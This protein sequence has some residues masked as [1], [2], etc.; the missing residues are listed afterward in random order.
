[1]TPS[2]RVRAARILGM[3]ADFVQ[4][5]LLPFFSPGWL[6]PLND[7]LDVVVA[8]A[9]IALVGWHWAFLPAFLAELIPVFDLVPSWTAAVLI[10][11]RNAPEAVVPAPIPGEGPGDRPPKDGPARPPRLP[12]A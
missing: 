11:T 8:I 5:G 2:G 6:S 1:V 9:M 3:T 12:P 4:I 10:A 7:A